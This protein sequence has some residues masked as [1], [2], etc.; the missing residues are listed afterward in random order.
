MI[1]ADILLEGNSELVDLLKKKALPRK[2]YFEIQAED[3]HSTCTAIQ[4]AVVLIVESIYRLLND[5]DRCNEMVVQI[6]C[7][8]NDA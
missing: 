8:H 4:S 2:E 1:S 5:A 3:G 6:S 7:D